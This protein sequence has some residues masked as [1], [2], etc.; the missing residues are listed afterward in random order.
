MRTKAHRYSAA[1]PASTFT[2]GTD[3][4]GV[5]GDFDGGSVQANVQ[6][7]GAP[8]VGNYFIAQFKVDGV[9]QGPQASAYASGASLSLVHAATLRVPQG[10]HRI[11]V[12]FQTS[13]APIASCTAELSVAEL[14]A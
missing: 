12:L 4:I 9:T 11:S 1:V 14:N 13:A 3:V 8:A 2:S 7:I 6:L 5:T 10:R